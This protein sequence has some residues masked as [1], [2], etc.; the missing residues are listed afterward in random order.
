MELLYIKISKIFFVILAAYFFGKKFPNLSEELLTKAQIYFFVP[1]LLFASILK[2]EISLN[3]LK[4]SFA[5][6][7]LYGVL[8]FLGL[9][10][11]KFIKSSKTEQAIFN[12][13]NTCANTGNI[14]IPV[15][16]AI[17]GN[18][19]ILPAI[20][21]MLVSNL[22]IQTVGIYFLARANLSVKKSILAI[23]K[24]PLLWAIILGLLV[25]HSTIPF[26]EEGI[27]E[28]FEIGK[29]SL[30]LGLFL[31]GFFLSQIDN[32][33]ASIKFISWLNFF[34]LFL[35]PAIAILIL[36]IIPV[37]QLTARTFLLEAS[38]PA[39]VMVIVWSSHFKLEPQKAAATVFWSTIFSV[40]II[41]FWVW[42]VFPFLN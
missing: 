37:D 25:K 17:L 2:W 29:V 5:A 18:K 12:F 26:P 32:F 36:R 38:M 20:L 39:A 14:G 3:Y 8:I 31:L 19:S 22:Y 42:L 6:F 15:C 21:I 33:F 16:V 30:Y 9:F 23:F 10:G 40:V 11:H 13:S 7:I 4:I 41:P 34:K 35:S 24:F 28:L 27:N 1:L